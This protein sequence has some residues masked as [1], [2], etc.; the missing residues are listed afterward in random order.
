MHVLLDLFIQPTLDLLRQN[1]KR[2]ANKPADVVT[3]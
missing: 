1:I 3:K 2:T